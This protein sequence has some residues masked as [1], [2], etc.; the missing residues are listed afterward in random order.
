[1]KMIMNANI[2]EGTL[3]REHVLKI[4]MHINDEEVNG[5]IINEAIQVWMI[6]ETLP[7]SFSQFKTK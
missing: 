1:M 7:L 6:L 4:I 2:R 5:A 3:S